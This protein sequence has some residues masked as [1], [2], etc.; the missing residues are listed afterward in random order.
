MEIQVL[1]SSEALFQL[2]TDW[3]KLENEDKS[4]TYY[5]TFHFNYS[6]WMSFGNDPNKQLFLLCVHDGARLA[7]IAPLMIET[8]HRAWVQYRIIKFIGRGDFLNFIIDR[9][10][11]QE[12]EI[13][14]RM[15]RE[16]ERRK[17]DW[18][19]IQ[20]THVAEDS[21]LMWYLLKHDRY[22]R[23]LRYLTMC[24]QV[25]LKEFR[26]FQD[27]RDQYIPAKTYKHMT[28]LEKEIGYRFKVVNHQTDIDIY[29][30]I[31]RIHKSEQQYLIQDKGRTERRSLFEDPRNETFLRSLFRNNPNVVTFL[32]ETGEGRL[33]AYQTCYLFHNK[34]HLWNLGYDPVF[35]QVNLN[36]VRTIEMFKYLF[37]HDQPYL[38][39]WGAGSYPWKFEWTDR[40]VVSFAF[41]MWRNKSI[42]ANGIRLFQETKRW[43]QSAKTI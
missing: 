12:Q 28:K 25:H 10:S 27:Y 35:T 37:E 6:W 26:S 34:L 31:A 32:L 14:D 9:N 23:H 43:V 24:P 20:L 36:Y 7:G 11:G 40:F 16:I 18:D 21:A 4:L 5:N 2:K 19:Q 33:M 17:K 1:T 41:S 22:Q 29:D 8:V 3:E 30:D 42:K 39:D 15:F 13:I 38:I